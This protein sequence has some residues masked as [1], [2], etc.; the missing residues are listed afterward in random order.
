M[1]QSLRLLDAYAAT[2]AQRAAAI[3]MLR[4]EE[5]AVAAGRKTK[6]FLLLPVD[7]AVAKAG[8]GRVVFR[9]PTQKVRAAC[10]GA[11]GRATLLPWAAWAAH[12]RRP[13]T[14]VLALCRVRRRTPLRTHT[15]MK[16]NPPAPRRDR[17]VGAE[18][19]GACAARW[20]L[21]R[22]CGFRQRAPLRWGGPA[23]ATLAH[24]PFCMPARCNPSLPSA[25]PR[26][27]P[28]PRQP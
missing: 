3:A 4:D 6:R 9:E 27:R 13:R 19:Q 2:P 11:P 16:N 28:R 25:G 8:E 17:A 20:R 15:H 22:P 23:A 24:A 14:R 7:E 18:D 12:P 1:E 26:D 21:Q 5:A 10:L